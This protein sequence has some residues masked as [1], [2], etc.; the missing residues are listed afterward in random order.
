MKKKILLLTTGGTIACTEGEHGFAPTMPGEALLAHVPEISQYADVTVLPVLNKDSSNMNP[1]DWICIADAIYENRMDYDGIVVL[2][3]TDTMAYSAAAV[4]F[5]TMGAEVPV[6]FTGAQHPV[7]QPGSDG[8]GN[9]RDAVCTACFPALR[10]VFLVFD[11]QILNGCRA[12]KVSTSELHAFESV[13]G[14]LMGTVRDRQVRLIKAPERNW[15]PAFC[16]RRRLEERV[17][18][19]K[20][21]PG[22]DAKVLELVYGNHYRAVILEAFGL[23]GIPGGESG[24]LEEIGKLCEAGILVLVTTQCSRGLCDMS[25]YEVGQKAL[26]AGAVCTGVAAKEAL[27]AKVMWGLAL[28]EDPAQLRTLLEHDFCG[29]LGG[30]D[31]EPA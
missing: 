15:E 21:V 24:I 9:L 5:M 7:G 25:V 26:E 2:H 1:G 29:E 28:T 20:L 10:G 30:R 6:V 8:P 23:G 27:L 12:S 11:G 17:L 22:M 16:W 14:S 19:L 4:S 3:G 18:F 13:G 31:G